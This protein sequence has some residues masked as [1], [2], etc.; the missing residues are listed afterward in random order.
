MADDGLT[1]IPAQTVVSQSKPADFPSLL[2][3]KLHSSIQTIEKHKIETK[4]LTNEKCPKCGRDEVR[5]N[6]LQL[7]SAD[8][9]TTVFYY[10]DCGYTYGLA[11][12]PQE[13]SP[14]C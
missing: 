7:R 3:Q 14:G 12:A 1:D 9:G 6:T 11:M 8:E 2:R 4:A 13:M 10:C 5:Y